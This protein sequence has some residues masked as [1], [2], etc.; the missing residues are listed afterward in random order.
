MKKYLAV[1]AG[2]LLFLVSSPIAYAGDVQIG[3][4][5]KGGDEVVTPPPSDQVAGH[6]CVTLTIKLPMDDALSEYLLERPIQRL[7]FRGGID[8]SEIKACNEGR[9][10]MTHQGHRG[11]VLVKV[12]ASDGVSVVGVPATGR[13]ALVSA[14][15]CFS[16]TSFAVY[17]RMVTLTGGEQEIHL[18]KMEIRAH[19]PP[20]QCA[21]S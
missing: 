2:L 21:N 6:A 19:E 4:V 15:M 8:E 5:N 9:K 1:L 18:E 20:R 14:S 16:P 13:K 7:M 12:Y 10:I 11:E 3:I 17:K